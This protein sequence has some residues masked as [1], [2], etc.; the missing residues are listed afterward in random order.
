M[1]L[2][3]DTITLYNRRFD[4]DED[5]DVYERTVIRGVHWFNSEATTVDSTGLKAANKVTIRIPTDADFGGKVY[6]PPKQY[7]ATDDPAAAFTLVA[8]DLVV[9]G[10]GAEDLR[11]AA[12]HDTYSEAATILQVTDNRRLIESFKCRGRKSPTI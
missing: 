10:I 12:I 2:C 1:Q 11:P 5:C 9:L 4:P 8:G 7:A 3:N 6:F